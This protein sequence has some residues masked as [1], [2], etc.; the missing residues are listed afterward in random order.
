MGFTF[1]CC[2]LLYILSSPLRGKDIYDI[3][4]S[5]L[6]LALLLTNTII[7]VRIFEIYARFSRRNLM[8]TVPPFRQIN[9]MENRQGHYQSNPNCAMWPMIHHPGKSIFRRKQSWS[10]KATPNCLMVTTPSRKPFTKMQSM[11][12]PSSCVGIWLIFSN[13]S[14]CRVERKSGFSLLKS[15]LM[16]PQ[17]I[18]GLSGSTRVGILSFN[19]LLGALL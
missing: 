16:S 13:P 4:K 15:Q 18:V 1:F 2:F 9:F 8:V 12:L 10:L 5:F 14:S 7:R 19:V 11:F 3:C 6:S 17:I